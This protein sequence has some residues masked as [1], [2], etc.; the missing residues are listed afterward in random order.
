[1][2]LI[3]RI[4]HA[5]DEGVD[6][7][8]FE[9]A[10][11]ALLQVRYPWLSPV[12]AGRDLGRDGDIY[13]VNQ[14]DADG[15]GRLLATTGDPL[16]NLK[17]SHKSWRKEQADGEFRVN[18]LV[19]ATTRNLTGTA[20]KKLDEYCR[21]NELP[22]PECYG[23]KWLV[24]AL[25]NDAAWRER[26]IGVRGRLDALIPVSQTMEDEPPPLFGRDSQL[27][28]IL[29]LLN[30]GKDVVLTGVAGVGKTRILTMLNGAYLVE[31]LARTHLFDDL[32]QLSPTTVVIDDA[33]LHSDLLAE[34]AQIRVQEGLTFS[35]VA[36]CWPDD[37]ER[38]TSPLNTAGIITL[39]LLPRTIIDELIC[40]SGVTAVRARRLILGQAEGRPGWAL[41]LCQAFVDSKGAQVFSGEALLDNVLRHLRQVSEDP[42]AIDV[43]ACMA[44]L[45]GTT[46]DD[47]EKIAQLQHRPLPLLM[48]SLRGQA[49][50]G[51]IENRG[52]RWH[53][54]TA[55]GA[56]LISRWFFGPAPSR[57][58]SSLTTSFPER[59]TELVW[60]LLNAAGTTGTL[61]TKRAARDWA[62]S[63]PEVQEWN[64]D[65]L[66]LLRK[67]ALLDEGAADFA[68]SGARGVLALDRS[69]IIIWE[70]K[71][72]PTGDAAK[73]VLRTSV[74][75][76]CN[77]AAV[78]G[79]L[80]LAL[81]D[82]QSRH[83]RSDDP[84]RIIGG[85]AT[86]LDPD[87]GSIFP[88]R[89]I[90]LG[91]LCSWLKENLDSRERW[92]VFAEVA[93]DV[94]SPTAEGAWSEP[95]E[96]RS[97]TMAHHVEPALRLKGLVSLWSQNVTPLLEKSAATIG[98]PQLK[99]LVGL[100]EDWLRL[101]AGIGPGTSEVGVDQ[102][103][104]ALAG[105]WTMIND[106]QPLLNSHPG[107]SHLVAEALVLARAW[108]LKPPEPWPAVDL[109][110]DLEYFVGHRNNEISFDEWETQRESESRLLADRLLAFGAERGIARYVE[111]TKQA[112]DIGANSDGRLLPLFI[113]EKATN[114]LD[115][116]KL[117]IA[118]DAGSLSYQ[119]L[120]ESRKRRL[121]VDL[122]LI[123]TGLEG[124]NT[125]G[126][127]IRA[128]LTNGTTDKVSTTVL[129][130]LQSDDAR[131]IESIV[132]SE[133]PDSLLQSLL[134]HEASQ[135]R[136]QTALAFSIAGKYGPALPEAVRP[137]WR[138]ALLAASPVT[139]TDHARWRLIETLKASQT[140]DPSLCA[141]WFTLHLDELQRAG[142][143]THDDFMKVA[144]GLPRAQRAEI[145]RAHK[146]CGFGSP[147][148]NALIGDD[149]ELATTLLS[150]GTISIDEALDALSG[151]RDT[152]AKILAPVLLEAGVPPQRITGRIYSHRSWTGDESSAIEADIEWFQNL[153]IH[154]ERLRVISQIAIAEL[155]SEYERAKVEEKREAI[156]G[157]S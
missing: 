96:S 45:K 98:G 47:L 39:E 43:L 153:A 42:L 145:C 10:A 29:N 72:D 108:D 14:D 27:Q 5:L 85:L 112:T 91:H 82:P 61:D 67:F 3:R 75:T 58:W 46:P 154:D 105:S 117:A 134:D 130:A 53:L 6:P 152:G 94:L 120:L 100:W 16:A 20:R 57:T 40:E 103:Q 121:P 2:T 111:L 136:A 137:Q 52:G 116:L 93:K 77:E 76:W 69:P 157:W 110:R 102:R 147:M 74:N 115:W 28:D 150:E 123:Q 54:Q 73:M 21:L 118:A 17:R 56:P 22:L 19:I 25:K 155:T 71:Y 114:P 11:T 113:S 133:T 129:D 89:R 127:V 97:F 149:G 126:A 66:K 31:P 23:R 109:D 138:A 32:M 12:E 156:R 9:D 15:R 83:N 65:T 70:T 144:R 50:R 44:A 124:K 119:F 13:R 34:I 38:I 107:A 8:L 99:I 48:A 64:A 84:L 86:H 88:V 146:G 60:A 128:V 131:H 63:L 132:T 68:S 141:E 87:R 24:N 49:T 140:D 51:I 81:N 79:L 37:V 143:R 41:T 125:R 26:L 104:E 122:G 30:Q 106:L 90:L 4:E 95:A 139:T 78:H 62:H 59:V 80:D 7:N 92:T 142:T 18:A 33:Q 36:T 1:M 101:A 55:L 148:L 151:E 35:V 135:I